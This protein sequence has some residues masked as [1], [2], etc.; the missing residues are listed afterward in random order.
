MYQLDP[1]LIGLPISSE[2]RLWVAVLH[3]AIFDLMGVNI[4]GGNGHYRSM[5]RDWIE[6][7]DRELGS[8]EWVCDQLELNAGW[9]RRGLLEMAGKK[10]HAM[11]VRLRVAV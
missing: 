7:T 4:Y 6:S 9:L 3:R 1:I 10:P 11:R 2:R 5:A 8:F